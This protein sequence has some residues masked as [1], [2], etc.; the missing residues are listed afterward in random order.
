MT[1]PLD[2]PRRNE[3]S[4]QRICLLGVTAAL[5]SLSACADDSREREGAAGA[6][7]GAITPAEADMMRQRLALLEQRVERIESGAVVVSPPQDQDG[8][9][10]ADGS[11]NQAAQPNIA[12]PEGN[13]AAQ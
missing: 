5:L 12:Q 6:T 3:R 9:N 7:G 2:F 8:G 10:I 4:V 11:G 13:Q 1:Y